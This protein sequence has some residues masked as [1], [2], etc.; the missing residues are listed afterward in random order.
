MN[1]YIEREM[2][3][4]IIRERCFIR[5]A[6]HAMSV[7]LDAARRNNAVIRKVIS[8]TEQIPAADVIEVDKV[9]EMFCEAFGDDCPCNYNNIDEWLPALCGVD[10]FCGRHDDKL[11]CWKLFIN[12][13]D[14]RREE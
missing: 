7:G 2:M 8:L 11:H 13:Y 3:I 5:S 10:S 12:H 14:E 4:N 9:A 6:D 1:E